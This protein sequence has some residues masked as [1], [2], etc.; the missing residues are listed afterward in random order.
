MDAAWKK[1]SWIDAWL[2]VS[3]KHKLKEPRVLFPKPL[4]KYLKE[5]FEKFLYVSLVELFG[6]YLRNP[7]TIFADLL[8]VLYRATFANN[9]NKVPG[10]ITENNAE[11]IPTGILIQFTIR[12]SVGFLDG[13]LPRTLRAILA[14]RISHKFVGATVLDHCM[15]VT[16]FSAVTKV[17]DLGLIS[18][19]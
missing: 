10:G 11:G 19:S 2:V 12:I 18:D 15:T 13:I 17:R 1:K 16:S 3:L 14:L 9:L 5:S 6:N 4:N 7:W 8:V